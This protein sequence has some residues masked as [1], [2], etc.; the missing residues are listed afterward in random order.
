MLLYYSAC[1]L[2]HLRYPTFS[3]PLLALPC[4]RVMS[5]HHQ[6][7]DFRSKGG[8]LVEA[9]VR[10]TRMPANT[11]FCKPCQSL[12]QCLHRCDP[13]E[14]TFKRYTTFAESAEICDLC[15]AIAND[16][17]W[18]ILP[19]PF[20]HNLQCHLRSINAPGS[21]GPVGMLQIIINFHVIANFAL[22][23]DA[24]TYNNPCSSGSYP[25]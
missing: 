6:S 2:L 4:A 17:N 15:R 7:V 24:G 5:L 12:L 8:T 19:D 1:W 14:W 10:Q 21:L 25:D 9:E 22:W 3:R 13:G 23:T 16:M 20:L 18:T 11:N